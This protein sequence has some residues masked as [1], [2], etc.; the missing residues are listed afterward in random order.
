MATRVDDY[1]VK[2]G[3]GGMGYNIICYT[4][5]V[6]RNT[7]IHRQRDRERGVGGDGWREGKKKGGERG[8]E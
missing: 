4:G 2:T 6:R 5:F 1:L 3:V 8:R 7:G